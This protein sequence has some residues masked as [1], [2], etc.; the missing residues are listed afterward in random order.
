MEKIPS[1]TSHSF[2]SEKPNPE[3]HCF[4]NKN[5]SRK[6]RYFCHFWKPVM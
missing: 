1:L 3:L 2:F 6:G 5:T 4:G